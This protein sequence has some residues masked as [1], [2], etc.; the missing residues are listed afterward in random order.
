MSITK[1]KIAHPNNIKPTWK[2][3][4]AACMY[5]TVGVLVGGI[6]MM[7]V[8]P[9]AY[10]VADITEPTLQEVTPDMLPN[11]VIS[12]ASPNAEKCMALNIYHEARGEPFVGKVAVADVVLNRTKDSR[13]PDTVCAVVYEGLKN[14]AGRMYLA[15]CQFSWY[16]DGNGDEPTEDMAWRESLTIAQQMLGSKENGYRGI[17]EGATHYHAYNINP[18]IWTKSRDMRLIGRIG[19]HIFYRWQ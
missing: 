14:I 17:T 11:R 3:A 10:I 19:D 9:D 1:Y 7:A 16:C 4:V 8:H 6:A 2:L 12:F 18:P 15:K 13:T 5:V